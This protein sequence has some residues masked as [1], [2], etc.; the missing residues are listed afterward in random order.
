MGGDVG[1]VPVNPAKPPIDRVGILA[2]VCWA[3]G[4][5]MISHG[6]PGLEVVSW[7]LL[8][9]LVVLAVV[10]LYHRGSALASFRIL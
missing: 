4:V 8:V 3:G 9:G 7:G 2:V 6:S 10:V 1:V 5:L